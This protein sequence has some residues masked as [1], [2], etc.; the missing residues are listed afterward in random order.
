M[1]TVF[2]ETLKIILEVDYSIYHEI[3]VKAGENTTR[4]FTSLFN[5]FKW[6]LSCI[7]SYPKRCLTPIDRYVSALCP[8]IDSV[9]SS[10]TKM[11]IM[12]LNL[13]IEVAFAI[14][15][16]CL[17]VTASMIKVFS[18]IPIVALAVGVAEDAMLAVFVAL[19]EVWAQRTDTS[20]G[21][22]VQGVLVKL[23]ALQQQKED[24]HQPEEAIAMKCKEVALEGIQVASSFYTKGKDLAN[25]APLNLFSGNANS[26]ISSGVT[27]RGSPA[28]TNTSMVYTNTSP[29]KEGSGMTL[30]KKVD[31]DGTLTQIRVPLR[32]TRSAD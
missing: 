24:L 23:R 28:S 9:A 14:C 12:V 17:Q 1:P 26:F 6:M 21:D 18:H 19:L 16:L 30:A 11:C 8:S 20:K 13:M 3:S 7:V 22:N 25:F 31:R 27:S 4:I 10:Y 32:P 5:L 2:F 15:L 29:E